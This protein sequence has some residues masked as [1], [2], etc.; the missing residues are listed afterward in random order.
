MQDLIL[1]LK[2]M[3]EVNRFAKHERWQLYNMI[4]YSENA[5]LIVW[6]LEH[7][8]AGEAKPYL[9]KFVLESILFKPA[10]HCHPIVSFFNRIAGESKSTINHSD[11]IPTFEFIMH[12]S[13]WSVNIAPL[14]LAGVFIQENYAM[15]LPIERLLNY[16]DGYGLIDPGYYPDVLILLEP[17]KDKSDYCYR[18]CKLLSMFPMDD[19]QLIIK[20]LNSLKEIP[21]SANEVESLLSLLHKI[22]SFERRFIFE[23]SVKTFPESRVLEVIGKI[24]YSLENK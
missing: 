14:E 24:A 7:S 2:P 5:E 15:P 11:V 19:M 23:T 6:L 13:R 9:Q 4:A 16:L 22:N 17:H 10:Y 21:H 3:L 1:S 12:H 8:L 18:V 20:T